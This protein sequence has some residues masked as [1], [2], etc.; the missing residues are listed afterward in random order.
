MIITCMYL[1]RADLFFGINIL[2][3][4]DTERVIYYGKSVLH[5]LERMF[6]VRLNRCSTGRKI[7]NRVESSKE[8]KSLKQQKL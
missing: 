7:K 3:Y 1:L 4:T 5:L 6:H 2:L 8:I